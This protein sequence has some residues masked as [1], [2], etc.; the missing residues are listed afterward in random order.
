MPKEEMVMEMLNE[1]ACCEATRLMIDKVKR[2]LIGREFMPE[3][4]EQ[5]WCL[6]WM[7]I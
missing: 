1:E 7:L 5:S 2:F 3:A 6:T 4:L